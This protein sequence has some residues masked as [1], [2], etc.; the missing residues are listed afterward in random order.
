MPPQGSDGG[1]TIKAVEHSLSILDYLYSAGPSTLSTIAKAIGLSPGSTHTHLS[2][3][4]AH[5]FIEQRA[6]QY[7]LSRRLIGIG[8]RTRNQQAVYQAAKNPLHTLADETGEAAHLIQE[9]EGLI[10]L[11]Y[12]VYGA[13]AVGVEYHSHKRDQ[14]I[15]HLHCT[16]SGKALLSKLPQER[17][18]EILETSGLEKNTPNTITDPDELFEALE[19][20]EERGYAI[21]DEEQMLGMRAVGV[22]VM[23]VDA[24]VAAAISASGPPS[25]LK[26]DRL[27]E[28]LR[29]AV[30]QAAE[31]TEI[32]LNANSM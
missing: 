1:R 15:R 29:D 19:R 5:G 28:D 10:L 2:T 23:R 27:H 24:T 13:K 17:V 32:N 18:E 21:A 12:E 11:L 25:R 30:L 31:K 20:I 8:E 26:G 16:A 14:L 22:P 4:A 7:A 3:L 9:Y 6:Q